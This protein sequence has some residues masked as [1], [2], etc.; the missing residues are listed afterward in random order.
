MYC[1]ET[2]QPNPPTLC[3][4]HPIGWTMT[5]SDGKKDFN[6]IWEERYLVELEGGG[7]VAFNKHV[8]TGSLVFHCTVLLLDLHNPARFQVKNSNNQRLCKFL[9]WR[10]R[11]PNGLEGH[12]RFVEPSFP[13]RFL[14]PC[15]IL[16]ATPPLS[17]ASV[18]TCSHVENDI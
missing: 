9:P 18:K 17:R 16:A 1:F 14:V 7:R 5:S 2:P 15:S 13:L 3:F 10:S 8:A 12:R 6:D 4:I 11:V